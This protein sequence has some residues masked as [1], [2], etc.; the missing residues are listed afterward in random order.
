MVHHQ[1]H[2]HDNGYH[3]HPG[4]HGGHTQVVHNEVEIEHVHVNQVIQQVIVNQVSCCSM[5]LGIPIDIFKSS[6]STHDSFYV[7]FNRVSMPHKA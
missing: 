7:L 5:I 6:F 4:H 2:H 1:V 3:G